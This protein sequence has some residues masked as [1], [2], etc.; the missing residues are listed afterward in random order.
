MEKSIMWRY[1]EEEPEALAR[2]L[3]SPQTEKLVRQLGGRPKAIYFVAHGS[4]FNA[5]VCTVGF[6]AKWA[7]IRAYAYTP[8]NFYTLGH[9]AALEARDA[10]VVVIS[11]TGTSSGALEILEY[12]RTLGCRTLGITQNPQAPVA[13]KARHT[14]HLLCGEE[15]SNAKTKGYGA[16]LLLLMRLAISFGAAFGALAP[17]EEE[18]LLAELSASVAS[19]PGVLHATKEFCAAQAFGKNLRNVYVL[20]G[21][22]NFGTAQEGQLKLMETMCMPTMFNDIVELSHGMHRALDGESGVLLLRGADRFSQSVR[23]AYEYVRGITENAWMLDAAGEPPL[24]GHCLALPVFQR[25]SSLLPITAAVQVLSAF[26]PEFSGLDPNRDAHNDFT[27]L[28]GTR[29]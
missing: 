19:L 16:T 22:V 29:V 28:A 7:G 2:Q 11:Q 23:Q 24:D 15:D 20:G 21:G 5:A 3:A 14:L 6:F 13:T 9:C 12:A 17:T 1:M 27:R 25:T 4:S 26:A 10:L 8:G 18:A